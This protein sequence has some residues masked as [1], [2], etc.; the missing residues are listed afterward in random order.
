M[1]SSFS[2]CAVD[3]NVPITANGMSDATDACLIECVKALQRIKE[4]GRILLDYS[5]LILGEYEHKLSPSGQPGL[6]DEFL[7]WIYQN[8]GTG[9]CVFVTITPKSGCSYNGIAY[10]FVEFPNHPGLHDFD[11]SDRKFV[12]VA[13]AH[14][15][16]PPILNATDTDWLIA[17]E[18]L[19]RHG[20]KVEFLCPEIKDVL[21]GKLK[22]TANG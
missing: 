20:I 8:Q 16:R 10:D 14:P 2:L 17:E 9:R 6:G 3:T 19:A 22:K 15:E 4:R 13:A 11:P 18:P 7:L 5:R 1:I 12:A 21:E